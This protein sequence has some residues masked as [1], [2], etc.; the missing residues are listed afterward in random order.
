MRTKT[1]FA[2]TAIILAALTPTLAVSQEAMPHGDRITVVRPGKF[3]VSAHGEACRIYRVEFEK[4]NGDRYE[5]NRTM[6]EPRMLPVAARPV[7]EAY[8]VDGRK[9]RDFTVSI[10]DDENET[11]IE[12]RTLCQPS[13][14]IR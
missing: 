2:A 3:W 8:R 12:G 13:F 4:P 7:G 6:C 1:L 10:V 5:E 11:W 14:E 9:C